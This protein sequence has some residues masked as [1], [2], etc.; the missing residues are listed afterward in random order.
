MH[1]NYKKF[2]LAMHGNIDN[3][4]IAMSS[5]VWAMFIGEDA[6]AIVQISDI[7]GG[8]DLSLVNI[9]KNTR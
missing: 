8:K 4:A 5:E 9:T 1:D 3:V 7:S 6:A 2:K